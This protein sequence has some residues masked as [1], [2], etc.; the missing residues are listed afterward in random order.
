MRRVL[1]WSLAA[2]AAFVIGLP[3]AALAQGSIT[4][5]DNL[6]KEGKKLWKNRGC[7]G[8]HVL[9]KRSAGPDLLGVVE[10]RGVEWV[11]KFLKETDTMLQTDSTAK[12]LLVEFQ[13]VKMPNLRLTDD[14]VTALI[15]YL[16]QETNKK[17]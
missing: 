10:R 14:Q 7:N 3:G 4:V 8:C 5:D 12:A 6:A 11:Q 15:H 16:Q 2:A 13:N 17:K 9:G 1:N